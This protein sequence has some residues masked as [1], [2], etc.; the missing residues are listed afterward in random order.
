MRALN[1]KTVQ[2]KS[3][4]AFY[5]LNWNWWSISHSYW[6]YAEM[7]HRLYGNPRD[8]TM[9]GGSFVLMH[10]PPPALTRR[11]F[12]SLAIPSGLRYPGVHDSSCAIAV[13]AQFPREP[14]QTSHFSSIGRI[15]R[16]CPCSCGIQGRSSKFRT[17]LNKWQPIL[18]YRREFTEIS[19]ISLEKN[20]VLSPPWKS[21]CPSHRFPFSHLCVAETRPVG[22]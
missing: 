1:L 10:S 5:G 16:L 19:D 21:E 22:L 7:G 9:P 3:F 15:V 18:C 20:S 6:L 12:D 2:Q 4:F 8:I 14:D 13:N 11:Q 17:V